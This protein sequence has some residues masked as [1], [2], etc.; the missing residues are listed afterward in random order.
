MFKDN[1]RS[2][3]IASYVC[4]AFLLSVMLVSVQ[5]PHISAQTQY[6]TATPG[7]V[8]LGMNTTISINAP[9]G[10]YT[11]VVQDPSNVESNF[12][13]TSTGQVMNQTF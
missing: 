8:N 7:Y 13:V 3:R 2:R 5:A 12:T 6:V 11:L 4:I 10:S 9:S 1:I